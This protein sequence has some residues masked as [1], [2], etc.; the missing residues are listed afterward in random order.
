MKGYIEIKGIKI[1]KYK[2]GI[3]LYKDYNKT[4]K[5]Q[6]KIVL[7]SDEL[8]IEKEKILLNIYKSEQKKQKEILEGYGL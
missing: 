8:F 1:P 6:E 3:C 2:D 5:K 4:I 7:D